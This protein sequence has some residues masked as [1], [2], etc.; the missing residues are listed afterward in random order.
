M[1]FLKLWKSY[2]HL[3]S[4]VRTLSE[5]LLTEAN[6]SRR[7]CSSWGSN[8]T[9]AYV[10]RL[11]AINSS[12]QCNN[13]WRPWNGWVTSIN[14]FTSGIWVIKSEQKIANINSIQ[15]LYVPGKALTQVYIHAFIYFF[16]HP[17]FTLNSH[18]IHVAGRITYRIMVRAQR[19]WFCE[20]TM[21]NMAQHVDS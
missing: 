17:Y 6:I 18:A 7:M 13:A 15:A 5:Q 4:A 14:S 8:K 21:K 11:S 20:S 10:F 1:K 19:T 2:Q 16:I 12:E 3:T 9:T